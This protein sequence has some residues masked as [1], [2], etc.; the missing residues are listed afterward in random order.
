VPQWLE[1]FLAVGDA[2]SKTLSGQAEAKD[3]LDAAASKWNDLIAQNPLSFQYT[4]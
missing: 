1:M 3:A 2:A 4:E